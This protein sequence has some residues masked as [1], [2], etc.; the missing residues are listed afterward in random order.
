MKR[1][2]F[3]KEIILKEY[4]NF[5][6]ISMTALLPTEGR[7]SKDIKDLWWEMT[8]VNWLDVWL[9]SIIMQNNHSPNNKEHY[10]GLFS[11]YPEGLSYFRRKAKSFVFWCF[12]SA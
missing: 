2:N 4:E 5:H 10:Q 7:I 9:N 1:N 6:I 8:K 11:E 3:S 12:I